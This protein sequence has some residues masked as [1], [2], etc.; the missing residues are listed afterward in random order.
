MLDYK[1][2]FILNPILLTF[3]IVLLDALIIVIVVTIVKD[4]LFVFVLL[5]DDEWS[6]VME[7]VCKAFS[8]ELFS[9]MMIS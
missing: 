3:Y 8:W 2:G 4:S 1:P 7:C 6:T 5:S 9:S